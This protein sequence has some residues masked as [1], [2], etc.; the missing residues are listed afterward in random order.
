M[1]VVDTESDTGISAS[2]TELLF[3]MRASAEL[4]RMPACTPSSPDEKTSFSSE[5][6]KVSSSS[7][8]LKL[9]STEA[10]SG[11]SVVS[12][13]SEA[14]GVWKRSS[15]GSSGVSV[16]SESGVSS[17]EISSEISEG[18]SATVLSSAENASAEKSAALTGTEVPSIHAERKIDSTC[19]FL[20]FI[21][22][23]F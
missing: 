3:A 1:Q 22:A 14:S 9:S 16:L 8:V 18:V 7:P 2:T 21:C 12:A 15:A 6:E 19:A 11:L 17:E 23:S 20:F 4:S 13:G 5:S 10:A